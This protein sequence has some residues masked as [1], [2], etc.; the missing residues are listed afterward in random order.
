MDNVPKTE[1][2]KVDFSKDFFGCQSSLTVSSQLQA[3][4]FALAY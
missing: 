2:G 4:T 3:E 1:D